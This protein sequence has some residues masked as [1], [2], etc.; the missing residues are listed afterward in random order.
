MIVYYL[1]WTPVSNVVKISG[2][3][4]HWIITQLR[5]ILKKDNKYPSFTSI[6]NAEQILYICN[7][8]A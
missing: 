5:Q 2:N 4:A 1:K 6:C 8:H 7:L 3:S